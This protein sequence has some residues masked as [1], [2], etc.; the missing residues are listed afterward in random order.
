ML[1]ADSIRR[2]PVYSEA[3][4]KHPTHLAS[5]WHLQVDGYAGYQLVNEGFS[6][7]TFAATGLYGF[8]TSTQSPLVPEWARIAK[9]YE[10][11]G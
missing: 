2:P 8:F 11:R 7:S 1:T 3:E 10:D 9:L 6:L 4:A 5:F